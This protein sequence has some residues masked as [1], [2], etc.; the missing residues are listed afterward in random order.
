[1]LGIKIFAR[2]RISTV[3][4]VPHYAGAILV[5]QKRNYTKLI[6]CLP[7]DVYCIPTNFPK[8]TWGGR[9]VFGT[10]DK[11]NFT[12]GPRCNSDS[13]SRVT[14]ITYIISWTNDILI[15]QTVKQA[16]QTP[17]SDIPSPSIERISKTVPFT[18]AEETFLHPSDRG[19]CCKA[20]E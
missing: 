12:V 9:A 15:P 16:P 19:P 4:P 20:R 7:R 8:T 6:S 2:G 5:A 10:E 11:C 13:L 14:N 3:W 17:F 18:K 1:M